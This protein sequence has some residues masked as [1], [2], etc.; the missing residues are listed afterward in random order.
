[1]ETGLN[2]GNAVDNFSPGLSPFAPCKSTVSSARA[3][4]NR[5]TVTVHA[6]MNI[7]VSTL[8]AVDRENS[9]VTAPC[10]S[11]S[12]STECRKT[13]CVQFQSVALMFYER[14]MW[15]RVH[16][17]ISAAATTSQAMRDSPVDE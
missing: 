12:S 2:P 14:M 3:K 9:T 11:S 17:V 1:M 5:S 7:V 6:A 10:E 15:S 13:V 4:V 8:N 16:C